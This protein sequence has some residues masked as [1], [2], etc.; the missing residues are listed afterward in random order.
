[1]SVRNM[2]RVPLKQ[3]RKW[4][5]RERYVFNELYVTLRDSHSTLA[6]R[7]FDDVKQ[8]SWGVLAWNAAWVAAD[9]AREKR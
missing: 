4:D 7:G 6:P 5:E 9:A 2:H 3:W 8:G 1:M